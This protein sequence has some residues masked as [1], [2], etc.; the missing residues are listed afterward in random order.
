MCGLYH[1]PG[2]GSGYR[3]V[4]GTAGTFFPEARYRVLADKSIRITGKDME[5][6]VV[7][8][9]AYENGILITALERRRYTLED[10]YMNLKNGGAGAC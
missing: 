8:R 9:L 7:S 2:C 1:N 3:K 10:Y 6:E 5:E 4:C